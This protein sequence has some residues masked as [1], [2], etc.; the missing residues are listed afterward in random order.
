MADAK[1]NGSVFQSGQMFKAGDEEALAA[2]LSE[3]DI[4]RLQEEGVIEGD[5]E[6]GRDAEDPVPA[7]RIAGPRET[8]R[9][10][11]TV[12]DKKG[13]PKRDAQDPVLEAGQ[14]QAP[15]GTAPGTQPWAAGAPAKQTAPK[16]AA[17]Q[18]E[19]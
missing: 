6:A 3:R 16:P 4:E 2:L 10:R 9:P 1:I 8:V 12:K 11:G 18:D 5:W 17:K 15:A 7:A 14:T 13:E 19:K